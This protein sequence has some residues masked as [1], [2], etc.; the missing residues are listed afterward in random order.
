[1]S[2]EPSASGKALLLTTST[3]VSIAP[4]LHAR[5]NGSTGTSLNGKAKKKKARGA[6]GATESVATSAPEATSSTLADETA[7]LSNRVLRV[8][9]RYLV[10]DCS[11]SNNS[12]E[13]DTVFGYVSRATLAAQDGKIGTTS[14]PQP[15]RARIRRLL[16]PAD[17]SQEQAP[18]APTLSPAPRV[19]I[20]NGDTSNSKNAPKPT[21]QVHD[22]VILVWS[23]EVAVPEG[24]LVLSSQIE[25][26][27][28]WDMVRCVLSR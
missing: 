11:A 9:P 13:I 18:G 5:Q 21:E 4:K 19:L 12:A 8:L 24:H 2:L 23:P 6:N 17:P 3:E 28:D 16:P 1:M 14:N 25:D 27:E 10:P 26:V 22:E 15:W 7:K 20:P